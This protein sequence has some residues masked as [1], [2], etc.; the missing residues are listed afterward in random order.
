MKPKEGELPVYVETK[1]QATIDSYLARAKEAE[2]KIPDL[3]KNGAGFT[4]YDDMI[5]YMI[6]CTPKLTEEEMAGV[7]TKVL[8]MIFEGDKEGD[9][10]NQKLILITKGEGC[11]KD[12]VPGDRIAVRGNAFKITTPKGT[13]L[14]VREYDVIGKYHV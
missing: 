4:P 9:V 3:L 10:T 11:K 2:T 6:I 1:D 8:D 14:A 12:M 13:F 7:D 5:L